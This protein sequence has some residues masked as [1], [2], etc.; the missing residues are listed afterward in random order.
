MKVLACK[1]SQESF[2][3][4]TQLLV[5]GNSA[6]VSKLSRDLQR[7]SDAEAQLADEQAKVMR[8]EVAVAEQQH[9]LRH[10]EELQK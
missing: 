2:A 6:I 8:L 10:M 9:Q 5:H 7:A 1:A 4:Y 3:Q